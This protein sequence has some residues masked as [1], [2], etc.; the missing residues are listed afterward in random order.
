MCD[1]DALASYDYDLPAELIAQRPLPERDASRLLVL[2]RN[3]GVVAHRTFREFP[4]LIRPHDLLVLNET[5]VIPARLVGRRTATRGKWEG[6]FLGVNE[7]GDWRLI[8]QTRGKLQPGES[9]TLTAAPATADAPSDAGHQHELVLTLIERSGD[10]EWT[11]TPES[12]ADSLAL[13][14]RFGTVPLPPYIR[15]D[16]P[17]DEDRE[18]YQT[19]FAH[20]PGAVAAPTAGLHFTPEILDTCRDRGAAIAAVTLHVGP[21]T[22]RPIDIQRLSE[23]RMHRE[24]CRVTQETVDA[25]ASAHEAGGRVI[26]VGTTTVRTLESVAAAGSLRP[27]CGETDLFIR[28]PYMFR[29]VDAL[30]TNFHLPRSTL[31][32]LLA[33][34]AGREHVL[35]AYQSAINERYRFYSYGDA[36]FVQ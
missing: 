19:T 17:T 28:P 35:S 21:G 32:V 2:D 29:V 30:L 24:W 27:F 1:P 12:D 20:T 18:R 13:L 3:A 16:T 33:A 7:A 34:F 6:L 10:G 23:H 15:R 5:R 8:G 9:I 14:D 4:E 36:M 11:A 22:F 31:L 26:A 25:V